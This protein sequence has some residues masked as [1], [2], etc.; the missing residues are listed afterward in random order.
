MVIV[1]TVFLVSPGLSFAQTVTDLQ[2][3]IHALQVEIAQLKTQLAAQ[4]DTTQP[5]KFCYAFNDNIGIGA[6]GTGVTNLQTVLQK[7]GESATVTGTYDETTA[8]AV[9][10]FQEK[11]R[12]DVLAPAGLPAGTGYVGS[13][14]RT[15]L[16][17]L[18]GCGIVTPPPVAC[19]M[20]AKPCPGGTY[21]SPIPPSC[22]FAACPVSTSTPPSVSCTMDAK[23]CPDGTYVGRVSP[24]CE[25]AACPVSTST[26]TPTRSFITVLSPNG[27]EQWAK[28]STQTIRWSTTKDISRVS[29]L[30]VPVNPAFYSGI[31]VRTLAA[32]VANTG[33]YSWTIPNCGPG[34]ECSSNF[35]ISTGNY[36]IRVID[37]STNVAMANVSDDSDAPFSIVAPGLIPAPAEY[38]SVTQA[39]GV[40]SPITVVRGTASMLVGSYAIKASFNEGVNVNSITIA[41]NP[42]ITN[43]DN[44]RVAA[45]GIFYGAAVTKELI[46]GSYTF[47]GNL[48]IPAGSSASVSVFAD[49]LNLQTGS[50]GALTS[51]TGVSGTGQ[52]SGPDPRFSFSGNVPGQNV[53]IAGTTTPS[54]VTVVS[55]NGGEQWQQGQTYQVSWQRANFNDE[56]AINLIDYTPGSRYGM[57]Y[58]I[59]NGMNVRTV[60]GQTS[61]SW[62]IPSS[63]PSGNYYKVVVGSGSVNGFSSDYFTIGTPG[64]VQ[65]TPSSIPV[66]IKIT[67]NSSFLTVSL[68]GGSLN[69]YAAYWVFSTTCS[70]DVTLSSGG[71]D[72][73][74]CGTQAKYYTYNIYDP[75]QNYVLLTAGAS[76]TASSQGTATFSITA[77]DANGSSLGSDTEVAYITGVAQQA[78]AVS[79]ASLAFTVS[80]SS[81]N[82]PSPASSQLTLTN[83]P[84]TDVKV[85]KTY[86]S[87]LP[88]GADW[89]V[90][91]TPTGS[92]ATRTITVS[93]QPWNA[94]AGLSAGTYT[95]SITI[96][97]NSQ[98]ITVPV[99]LSVMTAQTTQPPDSTQPSITVLSPNSGVILV[100]GQTYTISWSSRNLSSGS[101]V[102]ISLLHGATNSRRNQFVNVPNSG[103]VSWT[104]QT[105]EALDN[106]YTILIEASCNAYGT[107]CAAS[108]QSDAP[109][110][111][112]ANGINTLY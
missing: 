62:T 18:Y 107:N 91:G 1:S 88:S 83:Y 2:A 21:V 64:V 14:T 65:P 73:N 63:I 28:G 12:G 84:N 55:P 36:Y 26:K 94:P 98:T 106:T 5:N 52:I 76:N 22:E 58:G 90:V 33:S 27:G 46:T 6:T 74:S 9:S 38:L 75:S 81:I 71:G 78:M 97:T 39:S 60:S 7:D 82:N 13:R 49:V 43:F 67:N 69:K 102:T 79:P 10:V 104:V 30:L 40:P 47:S 70:S 37:S 110:S 59:T 86:T 32:D 61:F 103:S 31:D 20:V 80:D 42:G 100:S 34:N 77:Y 19:P 68:V 15:K 54:G 87:P 11:Y 35:E 56:V 3:Q 108:D 45:N 99:T 93:S 48:S 66:S 111:I 53:T 89:L 44:L 23:L 109:F 16:N 25:F 29:I 57:Q 105:P 96:I 101:T 72:T 4:Q 92:G 85:I 50:M 95:A 51:M 8:S 17:A 24:S 41:A 112:V